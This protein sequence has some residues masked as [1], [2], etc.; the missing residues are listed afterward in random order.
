MGPS[1]FCPHLNPHF[2]RGACWNLLG[3]GGLLLWGPR[4]LSSHPQPT[5]RPRCPP[6]ESAPLGGWMIGFFEP[7]FGFLVCF[8][9]NGPIPTPNG[10]L[11]TIFS[12]KTK[13]RNFAIF[14]PPSVHPPSERL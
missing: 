13:F 10:P 1:L 4:P 11:G 7:G 14:I 9:P 3:L 5:K 2:C 6:F 8:L 12:A